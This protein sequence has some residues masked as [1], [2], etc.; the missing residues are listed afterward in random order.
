VSLAVRLRAHVNRDRY[1]REIESIHGAE[2]PGRVGLCLERLL[3]G[4]TVIG[5]PRKHAMRIIED[6][7]LAS[8]PPI[9]R[10]AFEMLTETP[11]ETQ[12]AHHHSSKGTRRFGRA[13][14]RRAHKRGK[15]EKGEEKKGGAD[16][17]HV[18]PE[19]ADWHEKWRA[20]S[21]CA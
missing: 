9:R 2:G 13:W 18:D 8:T 3:A 17:W 5:V 20:T 6:V 11:A 19:W 1:S 14:P 4:L 12:A 15:T 16:F 21:S 7:A 10:H